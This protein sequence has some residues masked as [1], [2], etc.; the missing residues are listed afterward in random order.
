MKFV[1]VLTILLTTGNGDLLL[2]KKDVK[3]FKDESQCL[4][5]ESEHQDKD[6]KTSLKCSTRIIIQTR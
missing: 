4:L 6:I 1:L 3:E 5:L 2:V